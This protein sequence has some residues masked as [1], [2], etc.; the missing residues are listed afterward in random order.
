MVAAEKGHQQYIDREETQ[1]LRKINYLTNSTTSRAGEFCRIQKCLSAKN[2]ISSPKGEYMQQALINASG[3]VTVKDI[4][5][6]QF[7]ESF[8]KHL[9]KA[10]KIKIPNVSAPHHRD[11]N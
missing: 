1:Q 11:R 9:K 8:S 5:A 3:A 6:K 4:S 7:I 2:Y 10:N